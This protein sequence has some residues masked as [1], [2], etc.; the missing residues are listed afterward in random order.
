MF[1]LEGYREIDLSP[2]V[3][4]RIHR[5][6]GS[7]EEGNRDPYGKPWVMKEGVFPGDNSLFTLYW[8]P[9]GDEVWHQERMTSHHGSH[10]QGGKGHISHWAGMPADMQ[11][12]WEM[13]LETF[14]GEAAVCNLADLAPREITDPNEYPRG[15]GWNMKSKSGDL[16]GQ[17]ILPDHL[18]SI[19]KGDIVLMTSP[20]KGLE[21]PWLSQ[22]TAEWLI[23]DRQIKML[24]L[25]ALGIEWQYDLKV[26]SPHNSPLRRM[27][28]G[29]NIPIA[30]PLV[31]IERIR[32]QRVIYFGL[33]LNFKKFE[34][35]FIRAVA[36]EAPEASL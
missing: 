24:G 15:E 34:A 2:R 26:P 22:R 18:D 21:S 28:L 35:S 19:Q 4:A 14:I 29:A 30:H 33:P 7:I 3:K 32:S 36:F 13:P 23:N 11:G 6:D 12:L 17:E 16:R 8:A 25:G 10:V 27:F 1:S 31:N 9:P 20:F 5:A